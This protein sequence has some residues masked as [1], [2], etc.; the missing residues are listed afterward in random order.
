MAEV[1]TAEDE[2]LAEE[3]GGLSIDSDHLAV[4]LWDHFGGRKPR[5]IPEIVRGLP[6]ADANEIALY[7]HCA[8]SIIAMLERGR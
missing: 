2:K 3:L 7:R 4:L 5:T 8:R 6:V 1:K